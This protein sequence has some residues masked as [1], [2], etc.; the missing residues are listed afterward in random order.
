[1]ISAEGDWEDPNVYFD[2]GDKSD[3]FDRIL[4]LYTVLKLNF[5]SGKIQKRGIVLSM[6]PDRSCDECV[7]T[8]SECNK[9]WWA[10]NWPYVVLL[11]LAGL[12]GRSF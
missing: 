5:T 11:I 10:I 7:Q 3:C 1:M 2:F 6:S 9:T 4:A 12:V 8:E